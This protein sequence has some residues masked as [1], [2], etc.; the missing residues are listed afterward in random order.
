MAVDRDALAERV[1]QGQAIPAAQLMPPGIPGTSPDLKP[2]A[3]DLAS[4]KKLLAE[5]GYPNGFG[6]VLNS[7]S[8]RY[9]NDAKVNQAVAQMWTRLGLRT[10]V[11]T[12]PKSVFFPRAAKFDFSAVLGGNS[13]STAE[14]LSQLLNVLGTYE[15]DRTR[16]ASNHGRYSSPELDALL[17]RASVTL[18]DTA[19]NAMTAQAF[20]LALGRDFAVVPLLFPTT[21]WAMRPDITYGGYL[22]ETTVASMAHL[23]K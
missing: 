6:I 1:M 12:W 11:A 9:P 15:A 14:P 19:R 7:T 21:S 13:S 20:E 5:A 3:Y 17:T 4:A 10:K 2:V 16:G 18:D 8:D 22:Q 23:L